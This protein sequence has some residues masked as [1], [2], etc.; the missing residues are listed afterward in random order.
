MFEAVNRP[1][2]EIVFEKMIAGL[3]ET[4]E[5]FRGEIW[6]EVFI[7]GGYTADSSEVRKISQWVKRI[8]PDRVQ[9]N[10]V[11]RP[12]AE[13]YAVTV[14]RSRLGSLARLFEPTAE[15]IADYRGAHERADF[16]ASR[17]T[18]LHLLERRPCSLAELSQGLGI[19]RNEALKYIEELLAAKDIELVRSS[20]RTFYRAS[21]SRREHGGGNP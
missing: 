12:P 5:E 17:N 18:V 21:R 19:H 16:R 11:T 2:A 7:L 13:R 20:N 1:H 8:R 15:V 6:L 14:S 9:M 3:I 4:R 10:T